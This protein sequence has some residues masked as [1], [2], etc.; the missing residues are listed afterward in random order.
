MDVLKQSWTL[1]RRTKQ[2]KEESG[3]DASSQVRTISFVN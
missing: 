1:T 2:T 3:D